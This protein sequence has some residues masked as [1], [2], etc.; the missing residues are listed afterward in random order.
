VTPGRTAMNPQRF[1][2]P[3]HQFVIVTSANGSRSAP[4]SADRKTPNIVAEQDK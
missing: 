3:C 2:G 1:S 4:T